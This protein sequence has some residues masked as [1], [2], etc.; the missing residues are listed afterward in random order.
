M[1][2]AIVHHYLVALR[3]GERVFELLSEIFPEADLYTLIM[4]PNATKNSKI[5]SERKINT[6]FLQRLPLA[7]K[8]RELYFPLYPLAVE[9]WDLT[10]YDLVITSDSA[11]VK[12][13]I[14]GPKTLHICYCHSPMRFVWDMYF[15]H[16]KSAPRW[17]RL[18]VRLFTHYLRQFDFLA[19]QRV[20]YFIANS[21]HIANKIKKYYQREATVIYPPVDTDFF[22]PGDK[23]TEDFYIYV[24]ALTPYKRVDIIVEAFNRLA[25]P[26]KIIGSGAE[27]RKLKKISG[28]NIEFLGNVDRESVRDFMQRAKALVFA[29]E[30]DFGITPVEAQACGKPVIA[31]AKG[32]VLET[33]IDGVTGVLFEEQSADSLIK[34][35]KRF[36]QMKF[37]P[38][39]CRENALRFS[40]AQSKKKLKE[41]IYNRLAVWNE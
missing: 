33:V 23:E 31:Y 5:L 28:N 36:E 17:S 41:F 39:K 7:R 35:I 16:L 18:G 25:K 38:Q 22:V 3:G 37:D 9:S 10:D 2:V 11:C 27:I 13:V 12:G 34:A 20:D 8:K 21:K 19:A 26:L 1:K 40:R 24:G 29:A 6:S 4:D 32:G 30:E 14:T 15:L